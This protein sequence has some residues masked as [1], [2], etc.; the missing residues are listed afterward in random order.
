MKKN[1]TKLLLALTLFVVLLASSC[2]KVDDKLKQVTPIESITSDPMKYNSEEVVIKGFVTQYTEATTK[3]TGYY[4]IKGQY[5]D[6]I[7]VNTSKKPPKIQR[8]YKVRGIVKIE[9]L[10]EQPLIIETQKIPVIPVW[11]I[12]IAGVIVVLIILVVILLVTSGKTKETKGKESKAADKKVGYDDSFKTVQIVSEKERKTMVLMPGKLVFTSGDDKGKEI[13]LAGYPEGDSTK[14]TL[15]S[16]EETG[17]KKIAHI[18]LMDPT[19]S[20]SQAEIIYLNKNNKVV[21]KNLSKTNCTQ[22]NGEDILTD[23][24]VELKSG[25]KIK[26]GALVFE[27]KV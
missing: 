14:V 19:V 26:T 12:V 20:R 5:G 27:Y 10:S 2:I 4:M 1:Q 21:I 3:S 24:A 13:F 23:T 16:K 15:G 8:E 9:Y 22:V 6:E 17:E 7:Q 11:L 25:D 18:R